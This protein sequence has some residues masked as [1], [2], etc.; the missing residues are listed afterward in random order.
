LKRTGSGYIHSAAAEPF[1][2]TAYAQEL[3]LKNQ[4]LSEFWQKH[5]LG[6]TPQEIIASPMPRH[7]RATTK[8]RC[9]V[10]NGKVSFEFAVPGH[11]GCGGVAV[12]SLEPQAHAGV[13]RFLHAEISRPPFRALAEALNYIIIRNSLGRLCIIFNVERLSATIVRRLK[14]MAESLKH[15]PYPVA[16]CFAMLGRSGSAYY[17]EPEQEGGGEPWLKKLFGPRGI[18]M[19]F[20]GKRLMYPPVVFSQVNESMVPVMVREVRALCSPRADHRLVDLYCGYG[21]FSHAL[22]PAVGEIVGI[23]IDGRAVAAARDNAAHLGHGGKARFIAGTLSGELLQSRLPSPG[24]MPEI[25]ILDPPRQGTGP[26]IIGPIAER[27]PARVV[28]ICC[29]I[30]EIPRET[31]E[32][33]RCGYQLSRAVPLDMFAGTANVEMLM[34]FIPSVRRH[35]AH[36]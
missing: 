19:E 9:L 4:A 35:F 8:R 12:S 22:A 36:D 1:A 25:V 32:W 34:L 2:E 30:D 28:H 23:D 14:A 11:G 16:S 3:A 5:H 20:E 6:G 13:Y 29:G 17:L 10:R 15:A 27:G 26:D 24:R 31:G 7:Y 18:G 33:R 21:L